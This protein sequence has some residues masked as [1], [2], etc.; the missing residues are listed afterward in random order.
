MI[1]IKAEPL[2]TVLLYNYGGVTAMSQLIETWFKWEKIIF[3]NDKNR[4]KM[5]LDLV[6]KEMPNVVSYIYANDSFDPAA[7]AE[8][9]EIA[10]KINQT[11][12]EVII[13]STWIENATKEL[14]IKKL[15]KI[16]TKFGYSDSLFNM[17]SLE[18]PFRY[19][20]ERLLEE[21]CD[22]VDT[23]LEGLEEL[24]GIQLFYLG[25]AMTLC[26]SFNDDGLL[27]LMTSNMEGPNV[28]R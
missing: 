4:W 9:E 14:L 3:T 23:R 25:R 19:A 2:A 27:E 15:Q 1:E 7:Q 10:N 26:S 22:N 12:I 6:K 8:V 28:Y 21:E 16:T 17:T 18:H 20:Y 11:F 24:S 13:N 5:C